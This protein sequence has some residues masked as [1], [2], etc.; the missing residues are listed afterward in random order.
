MPF[1]SLAE[2]RVRQRIAK[3]RAVSSKMRAA[4]Q[5]AA[6][7]RLAQERA[8]QVEQ[9]DNTFNEIRELISLKENFEV[10]P[11]EGPMLDNTIRFTH[12]LNRIRI[13][14]ELNGRKRFYCF[15]MTQGQ[16]DYRSQGKYVSAFPSGLF[17]TQAVA[18][19]KYM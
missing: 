6:A 16:W 18:A 5:E 10:T 8:R 2:L 9:R 3:E 13:T 14:V 7:M 15:Q 11:A 17:A 1:V 4:I 12:G 19:L